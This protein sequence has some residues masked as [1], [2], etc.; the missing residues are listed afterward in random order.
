MPYFFALLFGGRPII[1]NFIQITVQQ[2]TLIH[3][4]VIYLSAVLSV[5]GKYK[6]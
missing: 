1:N 6:L 2:L 5:K 4:F 3:I